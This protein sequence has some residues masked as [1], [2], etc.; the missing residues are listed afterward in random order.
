MRR[1]DL[2]DQFRRRLGIP[3]DNAKGN[4]RFNNALNDAYRFL[5]TDLPDALLSEEVRFLS[6]PVISGGGLL[7]T[8]QAGGLD[9]RLVFVRQ[10][11]GTP[12]NVPVDGTVVARWL[13]VQ[14]KDGNYYL[15]RIQDVWVNDYNSP[16][17]WTD[18]NA[19]H[20][21]VDRQWTAKETQLPYRILT[22]DYPL[23]PEAQSV[24]EVH[25]DPDTN[26]V[27]PLE[28]QMR[29]DQNS[30]R[31]LSWRQEGDPETWGRGD[32][33]Q[34]P[35]PKYTPVASK[36]DGEDPTQKW[37]YNETTGLPHGGADPRE[38][39]YGLAGTFSYKVIHVWGRRRAA[40]L[41]NEGLLE[42]FYMSAESEASASVATTWGGGAILVNTPN[43]DLGNGYN[44]RTD[45]ASFH[46]YGVEKW[47]F[48]AR[49]A[50]ESAAGSGALFLDPDADGIYYLWKVIPGYQTDVEDHGDAD[51]VDT[52][53]TLEQVTGHKSIR[54]DSSPTKVVPI[55]VRY[56]RRPPILQHDNDVPWIPPEGTD[57]LFAIIASY[58]AG[59]RP[60]VLNMKSTYYQEYLLHKAALLEQEVM[61]PG[62]TFTF[63]DGF[64]PGGGRIRLGE[65][66]ST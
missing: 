44:P 14:G 24:L 19:L 37:G 28:P 65:I 56:K 52:R 22:I 62:T 1:S 7:E 38:P 49:H 21:S 27:A 26:T 43:I 58:L 63:G 17:G 4:A 40:R 46:H 41:T 29:R 39:K 36:Y 57:A 9:D 54:F 34:L 15:R 35:A 42:P 18:N 31:R 5:W 10:P 59:D 3:E 25:F 30:L 51:P 33:H 45:Y 53:I 55:L 8:W 60:G 11:I 48:R 12:V 16:N 6:D 13:E 23:P 32:F 66:S 64:G 50:N 47:I 61:E 20:I 2:R